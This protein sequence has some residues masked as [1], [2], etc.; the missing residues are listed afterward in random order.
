MRKKLLALALFA[1]AALQLSA[2]NLS[3]GPWFNRYINGLNRLPAHAT[4]YS[5][6]DVSTALAGDRDASRIASLNGTWKFMFVPDVNQAPVEFW[7]DGYD[8]TSWNDIKVPSCWEMQGFGYA[9]Y[10]NTQYPFPFNPPY[11]S[12]DN[13]VGSYVRTFTVPSDW[14]GGRVILHFGGVYS[15]HQV[16]VNGQEIG[17]SEDSCL[18]SEFDITDVLKP[19]ENTLAVRVFKWTDGS[20]LEDADHW[21]MA[22][23][24]REVML[25]WRPDVAITDFGV[26]TKLDAE[27]KNGELW[28]RPVVNVHDGAS[29]KGWKVT[30]TLFDASSATVGKTQEILVDDIL[31]EKCGQ[32]DKVH[33]PLL[34]HDVENPLKWTAETPNLY[35]LVLS[36]LDENSNLVEARSCKVGFREVKIVGQQF[37]INGT[38]IKFYG[39]NRHDH[40]Q[41][42]GKSVTREEMEAD[43]RLMKQFNFNSVRTCHYPNDPYLYELCDKYGIYVMDE[44]NIETHGVGGLI[45]NDYTWVTA[46]L[47]RGTRMVM[48]DRNHPCVVVWSLGNESGMGSNHAALSG[49]IKDFDPT[50][51]VHY[52]GAQS[53]TEHPLY[54]PSKRT[55]RVVFTSEMQKVEKTKTPPKSLPE[56][57]VKR[58]GNPTDAVY[59]DIISRMYPRIEV[60]EDMAL[61][62]IHTRPIYMCEYAHSMGN[63]TGSMKDY[64]DVIRKYDNLLGGHIWD[65]MDQG[66]AGVNENGVKYWKY[67]GDF[68]PEGEGHD[69][70]FLI[71]G[72]VFPDGTPKPA[73]YTC[74][75]VYQPVEFTMVDAQSYRI[76]L[77]NRNFHMSTVP[78][79]Y[80]WEVKDENGVVAKG[81]FSAPVLQPGETAEVAVPVKKFACK[82]DMTYVLNVYACES[83]DQFYAAAGHVN[84]SEQFVIAQPKPVFA[85]AKGKAPVMTDNEGQIVVTAGKY[86]VTFDKATG[87]LSGYHDGARQ[88][89]KAPFAP[90]FWRAELDNDWR[91][92][93]ASTY[94]GDWKTA[95]DYL[96]TDAADTKVEATVDGLVAVV[97]VS[98]DIHDGKA[99]L[100]MAYSVYPDGRVNVAYDLK[101]A[102]STLEPIRVGLQGQIARSCDKITYFGRGP[103]ENYSDRCDGIFLGTWTSTVEDLMTQYVF[104][105]ENGN[106]TGVEWI[107]MTDAKGKGVQIVGEQPLS[108]SVWNTTQD[109][110]DSAKHIGEAP[111]LEDSFVLNVDLVQNGVG[112]TD[113]WSSKSRPYDKYRLL[114]KEYSYGFWIVPVK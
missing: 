113:T 18:P 64:W 35:T 103:Q 70:N 92:W 24:H 20:Y 54:K 94:L 108:V 40:S 109:A 15:G 67:G 85:E 36:L 102:E 16:W 38:P 58:S 72:V 44:A 6:P 80:R 73:M 61:D 52:E 88:L 95:Q 79:I 4:S 51:P 1:V 77:K 110:L 96:A 39:V 106:R 60:L 23:I 30:T 111:V 34:Q 63:S 42:G 62:T 13:P 84:S 91:G 56:L 50:R 3:E 57:K 12:R 47:E 55:S 104:P 8:V 41:F 86:T 101:I 26:R 14:K 98:K 69:A 2:E 10:R 25:M 83:Q 19:G 11:I 5:Y 29:T 33:Y 105:Q 21:R 45:T 76:A 7:K 66:I 43:V 93:K 82:P 17:Y 53:Q 65:W 100:E 49:W 107:S 9:I 59:V 37:L 75:Y 114:E 78:Y 99:S 68:E 87:Y 71:N 81:E 48:R 46:F 112:G 97:K 22:G 31:S 32:R 28:V 27:Y 74:K 90:N 89:V